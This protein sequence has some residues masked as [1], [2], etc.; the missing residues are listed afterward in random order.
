MLNYLW[1]NCFYEQTWQHLIFSNH[2]FSLNVKTSISSPLD[3]YEPILESF[4]QKL[5][6]VASNTTQCTVWT[7][8]VPQATSKREKSEGCQRAATEINM[9]NPKPKTRKCSHCAAFLLRQNLWKAIVRTQC[10]INISEYLSQEN[11][12]F[13]STTMLTNLYC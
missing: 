9:L 8:Q 13:P 11:N 2:V 3:I 7:S 10:S 12:G 4:Q 5:T 6:S 1:P